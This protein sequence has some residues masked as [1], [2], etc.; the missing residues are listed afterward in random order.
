MRYDI[1]KPSAPKMP[2]LGKGTECIKLLLS[3]ASKDKHEPLVPMFF[4]TFVIYLVLRKNSTFNS[5][6]RSFVAK[7]LTSLQKVGVTKA[8]C[9]N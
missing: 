4:P 9:H 5:F 8:I 6:G 2:K 1:S 7:W 3:Q